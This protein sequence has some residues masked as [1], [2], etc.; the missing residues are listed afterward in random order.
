[1]LITAM[2]HHGTGQPLEDCSRR[3]PDA[4]DANP[5]SCARR[6]AGG[7]SADASSATATH[8]QAVRLAAIA[9]QPLPRQA[10]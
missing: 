6:A 2:E 10:S 8:A 5:R 1:M 4:F 3:N 9:G 7:S